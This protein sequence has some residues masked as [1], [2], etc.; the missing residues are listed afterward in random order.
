MKN[1]AMGTENTGVPALQKLVI[2][3]IQIC[4]VFVAFTDTMSE[5]ITK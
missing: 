2:G 5:V 3:E 4:R 1:N